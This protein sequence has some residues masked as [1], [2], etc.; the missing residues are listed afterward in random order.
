MRKA[1]IAPAAVRDD[2]A[3]AKPLAKFD[4]RLDERDVMN[5]RGLRP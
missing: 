5:E 2:P 3:R 4:A 1:F